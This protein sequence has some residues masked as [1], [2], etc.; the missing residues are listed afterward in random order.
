MQILVVTSQ[1]LLKGHIMFNCLFAFFFLKISVTLKAHISAT[2]A[3][4]NQRQRAFFLVFNC[5]SYWPIKKLS[6]ISMDG[7]FQFYFSYLCS[8]ELYGYF[9]SLISCHLVLLHETSFLR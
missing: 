1:F 5:L 7:D 9:L 4:I 2:E 3:D 6:N 8:F